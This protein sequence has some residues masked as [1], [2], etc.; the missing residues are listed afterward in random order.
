MTLSRIEIAGI[1]RKSTRV[2]LAT[3]VTLVGFAAN[4]QMPTTPQVMPEPNAPISAERLRAHSLFRS[5]TG[6]LVPIDDPRLKEM[7]AFLVSGQDREAAKVATR[8]PNFYDI[9]VRDLA[10]KM[11]ARDESVR[12]PL[13]DFVATFVG[14][15]RDSDTTSGKELLTGNF[16]YRADATKTLVNGVQQVRSTELADLVQSNNHYADLQTRGFSLYSVLTKVPGQKINVNGAATDIPDAAG[17]LTT[18]QWMLAHADAGTNR[19]L[20]EYSFKEFMCQPMT[21]W[22]DA[23]APDDRVARDVS[24]TPAGSNEKYLTTCKACH[25]QMDGLRG[26]FARVDFVNN[27]VTYNAGAIPLNGKMNRNQQE[28][29]AGYVTTDATWVNYATVGKN[30]DQFGWRSSA[31]GT[32]MGAF[33]AMIAN[34]QGFSRCMV[35][36][37]FSDVCKREPAAT[38]EKMIRSVADQFESSGYHMRGLFE[39]VAL[40]PECGVNQ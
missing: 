30:A 32:G 18:R 36:R 20:V 21:S 13:N 7:E 34:S 27:Q 37:I 31:T 23:T 17:L 1:L 24:R 39:V 26:A 12:T 5:L 22:A 4:A 35:R 33:G 15:V 3:F 9:R 11:S 16:T 2:A 19:R 29:P 6:T 28:F 8:D 38:E 10:R 40:R 25:G 14:V